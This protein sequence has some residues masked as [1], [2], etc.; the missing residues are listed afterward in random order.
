MRLFSARGRLTFVMVRLEKDSEGKLVA[1]AVETGA[2][3]AIT[4]LAKADGYVEIQEN[5]QFVDRGEEVEVTLFR[6]SF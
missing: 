4:T 3:G 1:E 5:Q 6:R 2:S